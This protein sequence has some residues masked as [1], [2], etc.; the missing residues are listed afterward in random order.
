MPALC[1]ITLTATQI[2]FVADPVP[3]F[4][5]ERACRGVAAAGLPGRDSAA[6]QRDEQAHVENWSQYS[7]AE[8]TKCHGLVAT[9]GAASYVELLT[10]PEM[11]KQVKELPKG[12]D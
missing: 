7:A 1:P 4:D 9:G 2:V 3:K 5:L 11:A 8:R 10:C 12:F 6:C